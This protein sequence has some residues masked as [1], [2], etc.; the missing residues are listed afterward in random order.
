MNHSVSSLRFIFIRLILTVGLSGPWKIM[1]MTLITVSSWITWRGLLQQRYIGMNSIGYANSWII[2]RTRI[3]PG[4]SC[5]GFITMLGQSIRTW[6]VIRN[7]FR[8][9]VGVGP[10]IC[11][12]FSFL[13]G[14]PTQAFF[15]YEL[16]RPLWIQP[17]YP[18]VPYSGHKPQA[19]LKALNINLYILN[20]CCIFVIQKR[21][22]KS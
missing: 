16:I 21:T 11:F 10:P 12:H 5:S 15:I 17:G 13:L 18:L 1:D 4:N 20:I 2:L 6:K 14:L 7:I 19:H 3:T 8:V 22:N 9:Q